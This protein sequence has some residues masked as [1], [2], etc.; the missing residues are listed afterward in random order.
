[1]P[2]MVMFNDSVLNVPGSM[3]V[4][5]MIM[6]WTED[7][8][9]KEKQ[10]LKWREERRKQ[11]MQQKEKNTPEQEEERKKRERERMRSYRAKLNPDYKA[12]VRERDRERIKRRRS[13][14][15]EEEKLIV[16]QRNAAQK[17][18]KRKLARMTFGINGEMFSA[19]ELPMPYGM[20]DP[21]NASLN[22]S[23]SAAS[24]GLNS[25]ANLSL[26]S[27]I[28][29]MSS[30]ENDSMDSNPS[31]FQDSQNMTSS[32][33]M[34]SY[35]PYQSLP[36]AFPNMSETSS[37]S[38]SFPPV[39]PGMT[40]LSAPPAMKGLSRSETKLSSATNLPKTSPSVPP[41]LKDL[42]IPPAMKHML[43]TA[44]SSASSLS[45]TLPPLMKGPSATTMSRT[46]SPGS[47]EVGKSVAS[48][49]SGSPSEPSLLPNHETL[50]ASGPAGYPMMPELNAP[51]FERP[52]MPQALN[53][54]PVAFPSFVNASQQNTSASTVTKS[55]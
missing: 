18:I 37:V 47:A 41:A 55:S 11:R 33:W 5:G 22:S 9:K 42:P 12:L 40:D 39:P 19:D 23:A 46:L 48:L 4:G 53:S 7:D 54:L 2:R 6:T 51:S 52:M 34:D 35:N 45:K 32:S 49:L 27:S 43:E 36:T 25:S 10:R 31:A 17:R 44:M 30:A 14:M 15:T 29:G 38:K 3:E 1:M 50:P 16:R 13:E 21:A 26:N 20:F 28:S 8:L 24:L